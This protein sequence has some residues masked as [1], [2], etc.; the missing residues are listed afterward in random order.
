LF[1]F[2]LAF[3]GAADS[4]NFITLFICLE[5]L[6]IS[7]AFLALASGVFLSLPSAHIIS[8]IVFAM[9][10]ADSALGLGLLVVFFKRKRT[11]RLDVA[12]L[13]RG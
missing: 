5:M 3:V 13:L 4:K 8:L 11:V 7:V 12:T 9:A 2:S 6:Q 10:G 1:T